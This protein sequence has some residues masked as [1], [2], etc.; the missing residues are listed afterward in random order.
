MR[1]IQIPLEHKP[2]IG[3]M[4][5]GKIVHETKKTNLILKLFTYT[6]TGYTNKSEIMKS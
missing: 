1:T 6:R 4:K 5:R 3:L 2:V